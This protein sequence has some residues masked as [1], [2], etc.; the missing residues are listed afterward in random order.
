MN[1]QQSPII[2]RICRINSGEAGF[3]TGRRQFVITFKHQSLFILELKLTREL[4]DK[5]HHNAAEYCQ[6]S[7]TRA[8]FRLFGHH[9]AVNS[10]LLTPVLTGKLT[11]HKKRQC[12]AKTVK[13]INIDV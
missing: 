3:R 4:T 5:Y 8:M 13:R 11:A 9:P 6:L 10:A 12:P 1:Y 7:Q 2:R